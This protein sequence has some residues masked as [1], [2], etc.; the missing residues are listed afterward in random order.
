MHAKAHPGIDNKLMADRLGWKIACD[1]FRDH[2]DNVFGI[3]LPDEPD[4]Q[5]DIRVGFVLKAE[6]IDGPLGA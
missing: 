5:R 3:Q 1:Q 6:F 4:T 2:E